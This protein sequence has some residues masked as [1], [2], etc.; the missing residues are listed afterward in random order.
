MNAADL[1]KAAA[2]AAIEIDALRAN[3]CGY[4]LTEFAIVAPGPSLPDLIAPWRGIVAP[5]IRIVVNDAYRLLPEAEVMFAADASW[6]RLHR[7][8]SSFAGAKVGYRSNQYKGVIALQTSGVTGYDP[9]P[10]YIRLGG[11]SGC[12]AIHLAAQLGAKT[13]RLIGF[14]MKR[15][16]GLGH[17]FGEHPHIPRP[18]PYFA[19]WIKNIQILATELAAR[20]IEVRNET[21]GSALK[22]KVKA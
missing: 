21:P 17:F 12:G 5:A 22:L 3:L 1:K 11:N 2:V 8:V 18:Q 19:E 20:G 10:G 16:G 9:R 7:G 14:D 6:W 15:I 13:I 4:G